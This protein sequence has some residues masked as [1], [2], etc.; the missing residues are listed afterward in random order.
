MSTSIPLVSPEMQIS[1]DAF[2][3]NCP[4]HKLAAYCGLPKSTLAEKLN[5]G[6]LSNEIVQQIRDV[7]EVMHQIRK[8]AGVPVDWSQEIVIAPV[9]R[10]HLAEFREAED[11]TPNEFFVIAVG[12]INYF[13]CIRGNEVLSVSSIAQATAFPNIT[14]A[15]TAARELYFRY[16][17]RADFQAIQNHSIKRKM[18]EMTTSFEQCGLTGNPGARPQS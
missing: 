13:S 8:R 9:I 7:L 1:N 10:R 3:L 12:A 18:S 17:T 4:I 14:M 6:G 2:A 11:P 5:S 15:G 16:K